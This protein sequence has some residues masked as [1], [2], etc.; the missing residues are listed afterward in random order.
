MIRHF[1]LWLG[2]WVLA[3]VA[4]ATIV[5][6]DTAYGALDRDIQMERIM[7]GE[8]EVNDLVLRT[9]DM[10]AGMAGA[11]Q[12]DG[13]DRTPAAKSFDSGINFHY[14]TI[15]I[16]LYAG[17]FRFLTTLVWILPG[18]LL[19]IGGA[20]DGYYTRKIRL[21]GFGY[22]SPVVYNAASHGLIFLLMAPVLYLFLPLPL[23]PFLPLVFAGLMAITLRQ[24][25]ASYQRL[26]HE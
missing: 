11:L 12:E 3:A 15:L 9:N 13:H 14:Q 18:L 10:M 16:L 25:V 1:L 21:H 22:A 8:D 4:A 20:V 7:V 24:V 23:P 6:P 19:I 17:I 2:I 5:T 26:S